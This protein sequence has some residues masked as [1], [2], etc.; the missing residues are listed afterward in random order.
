[1]NDLFKFI[2]ERFASMPQWVQV[3]TYVSFV[4]LFI[5]LLT[6][7]RFLD[8]RL[9]SN[10]YDEEF[11]I[12]GA[13]IEVEI[14]GRVLT[15]LTDTKGRFSVPISTSHPLGSYLFILTPDSNSSRIKEIQIPVSNSYLS[16][17][18]IIYSKK[19][20]NYKIVPNGILDKS[21]NTLIS[22]NFIRPVYADDKQINSTASKDEIATEILKSLEVITK[23]PFNKITVD[24]S[25]RDLQLDNIDLSYINDRL[26][27]KY[28]I[29]SLPDFLRSAGTVED[30]ITIANNKYFK[31]KPSETTNVINKSVAIA[32][33]F[34]DDIP[35]QF[36]KEFKYA[37]LLRKSKK[38]DLAIKVLEPIV[39][40]QPKFYLAWLNLALAYED[41]GDN[42]KAETAFLTA[43]AIEQERK[44]KD[45]AVYNAYGMYL[46]KLHKYKEAAVQF[47]KEKQLKTADS[48]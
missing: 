33:N 7:P 44:L 14:S 17:S 18:K 25:L 3:L 41:L 45:S 43:I 42:T 19:N 23:I 39:A 26:N 32:K 6:A 29:D 10:D 16:R 30:L 11:P 47:D 1:M 36:I 5:Y 35:S 12:G 37:K 31:N 27:K 22:L 9:V 28:N 4:L 40:Q 20:N 38:N 2:K 24:I 15:L 13:Q 48:D 8:M 21:P 34:A 46:F